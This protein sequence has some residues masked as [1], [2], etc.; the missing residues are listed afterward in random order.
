M[1][2]S[3]PYMQRVTIPD[4]NI[5]QVYETTGT[6]L[7]YNNWI[8]AKNSQQNLIEARYNADAH[9]FQVG[10]QDNF[11]K[12]IEIRLQESGKDVMMDTTI[13]QE[14]SGMGDRGYL[15]WGIRLQDL[16]E[17]L[18]VEIDEAVLSDLVPEGRL[19]RVINSRNRM[20][21][22]VFF[23]SIAIGWL[24]WET[25]GDIGIMYVIVLLVPILVITGLDLQV[26]RGLSQRM[27]KRH[28]IN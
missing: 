7:Q 17:M 11:P 12:K 1:T 16:Y 21:M 15:Y 23:A 2:V 5:Q 18:G 27:R 24:L 26:Y 19:T 3:I 4:Q 28:K 22:A 9:M 13:T 20:I 8:L 6:W 25:F 10:P 14:I